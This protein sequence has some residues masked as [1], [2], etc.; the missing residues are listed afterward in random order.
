MASKTVI[1]PICRRFKVHDVIT[2]ESKVQ[3][4]VSLKE[5]VSV[6]RPRELVRF[7]PCHVTRSPPIENV[8]ELG[9]MRITIKLI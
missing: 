6:V 4:V 9:G 8:F 5:L 3:V 2:C 1:R 7:D